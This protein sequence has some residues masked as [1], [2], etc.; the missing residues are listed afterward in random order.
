MEVL[1]PAGRRG[2][3]EV[4][5]RRRRAPRRP[6]T[7]PRTPRAP[8][9]PRRPRVLAVVDAAAGQGPRRRGGGRGRRSGS[10]ARASS[11]DRSGRTPRPAAAGTAGGR[12]SAS[13]TSGT[14]ARCRRARRPAAARPPRPSSRRPP[15]TRGSGASTG[16]PAVVD[17]PQRV[18]VDPPPL[19]PGVGQVG[20]VDAWRSRRPATSSPVSSWTSRTTA[21]RGSSPWSRPPPGQGPQLLAW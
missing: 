20:G 11:R 7:P 15:R 10:A 16:D 4:R 8:R 3:V 21:S 14:S 19:P 13:V 18:R 17:D 5:G 6:R 9:A 1:A 12:P 2:A